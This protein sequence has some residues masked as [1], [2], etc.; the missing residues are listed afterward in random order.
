MRHRRLVRG[1]TL[2][3]TLT[4]AIMTVLVLSGA[5]AVLLY[6]LT[7]WARGEGRIM[8]ETDSEKAIRFVSEK[9]REAM[10]ISVDANGLGLTYQLP[11]TDVNGNYIT[12]Q[13]WDGV[14]RRIE[15]DG[16]TLNLVTA[17][18]A[19]PICTGIILTDPL[20]STGTGVYEIFTSPADAIT[21]QVT[22]EVVTQRNNKAV[23]VTSRDRETIYL[24]N[25]PVL[26]N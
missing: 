1:T 10:S 7:S 24:R 4:A 3:E 16:T 18:K 19:R 8:A 13:V 6:G 23:N 25:V 21:R 9:L 11:Q 20:S 14:V 5:V 12:P 15:L 17:G 26:T 2:V 22:V